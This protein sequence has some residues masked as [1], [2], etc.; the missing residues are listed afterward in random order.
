MVGKK[1]RQGMAAL[2]VAFSSS[3]L[4]ATDFKVMADYKTDFASINTFRIDSVSI[5]RDSGETVSQANLDGLREVVREQLL[6]EGLKENDDAP[7][8]LVKISA[9][10][11]V[12]MHNRETQDMPW[13]EGGSW[14]ILPRDEKETDPVTP[15]ATDHYGQGT[16]QIDIRGADD[17]VIWRA[18]IQD[19]VQL[20][21]S[22]SSI[23]RS[24]EQVFTHY[25]PPP[26]K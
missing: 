23:A 5:V 22:R 20:P 7:D 12:G 15:P 19:V 24:L 13:F 1:L 9:G 8:V 26:Q 10:L 16:L 11:V 21:V 4:A 18:Y 2:I 17:R 3:V 6:K 25:P 14:H